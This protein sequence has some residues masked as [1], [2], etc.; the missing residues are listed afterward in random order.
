MISGSSRVG[1]RMLI[2]CDA[3]LTAEIM[4]SNKRRV[5]PSPGLRIQV[6]TLSSMLCTRQA[7][8]WSFQQA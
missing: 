1:H 3:E 8:W 4:D 6:C 2:M 7:T 5:A